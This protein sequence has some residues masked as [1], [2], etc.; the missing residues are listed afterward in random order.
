MTCTK[1][2][3][4][5]TLTG[6]G[7]GE[8]AVHFDAETTVHGLGHAIG[9]LTLSSFQNVTGG[10]KPNEAPADWIAHQ[11]AIA[12]GVACAMRNGTLMDLPGK[13]GAH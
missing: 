5:I 8:I 12:G 10:K 6:M 3:G 1:F 9:L 2:K 4:T 7:D 11:M 13:G